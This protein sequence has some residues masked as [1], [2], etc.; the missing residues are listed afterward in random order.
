M[1]TVEAPLEL[2]EALASLR[3]PPK[4][5]AILQGLTD[6]NTEGTLSERERE[7]LEGLVELSEKMALVRAEALRVLGRKP[8]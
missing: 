4:T 2:M 7:A 5:D 6:R 1:V 3:F 8:V